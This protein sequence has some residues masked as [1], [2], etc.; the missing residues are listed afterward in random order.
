MVYGSLLEYIIRGHPYISLPIGN[1]NDGAD[2]TVSIYSPPERAV[3]QMHMRTAGLFQ[4][5]LHPTDE[6]PFWYNLYHSQLTLYFKLTFISVHNDL[7]L[8]QVSCYSQGHNIETVVSGSMLT[9]LLC[10]L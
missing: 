7:L 6:A 9:E 3:Q 1:D 5:D 8:F 10:V 4:S 2:V